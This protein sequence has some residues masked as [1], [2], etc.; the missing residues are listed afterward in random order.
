MPLALLP[1]DSI[2]KIVRFTKKI[3]VTLGSKAEW[4]DSSLDL[5]L[6]ESTIKWYT[7]GSKTTEGIGAGVAG[8]STK[9]SNPMGSF[10][11]IFRAENYAISRCAE[12]NLQRN[13]CN[14][15]IA[16]LSGS[17][18][19]LKPISAYEV[20]SLLVQE[21]IERLNSLSEHSRVHLI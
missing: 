8:P 2:T 7:D 21:C 3:K 1:R 18:A 17:Q 6:R 9:L 5:L 10:P 11:S 20:R 19:A 12:I 16:I 15:S 14:R 13:Y 4:N